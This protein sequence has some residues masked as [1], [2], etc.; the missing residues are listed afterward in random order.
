MLER[1]I[2]EEDVEYCL[3]YYNVKSSPRK[4]NP[5]Y[6]ATLPSGKKIKVIV[7]AESYDPIV[8]ITTAWLQ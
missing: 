7:K 8:I 3:N 5:I 6:W 1:E 4:G 2:S